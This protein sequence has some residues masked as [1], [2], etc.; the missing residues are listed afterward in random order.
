[1]IYF[2]QELHSFTCT[3][4]VFVWSRSPLSHKHKPRP[5]GVWGSYPTVIYFRQELYSFHLR[6]VF[7]WSRSPLASTTT[8]TRRVGELPTTMSLVRTPLSSCASLPFF[9]SSYALSALSLYSARG[10][11]SGGKRLLQCRCNK[12]KPHSA[13]TQHS[14]TTQPD[15]SGMYHNSDLQPPQAM[16]RKLSPRISGLEFTK[17]Y[18]SRASL[19]LSGPT[20]RKHEFSSTTPRL[21]TSPLKRIHAHFSPG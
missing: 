3:V 13:P 21:A 6:I 14:Y 18:A 7:V 19:L 8:P 20:D 15:M 9:R 11:Y 1:V 4:I 2:R 10:R 12:D 16:H 17:T 5:R